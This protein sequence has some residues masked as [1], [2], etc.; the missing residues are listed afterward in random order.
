MVHLRL[1]TDHSFRVAAGKMEEVIACLPSVDCAITDR[2]GTWGHIRWHKLCKKSGKRA[3]F[4]VE[5]GVVADMESREKQHVNHMVFLARTS[6]GLQELY[7]L[8]S[9]STE[10]FYYIPRL[11]YDFVNSISDNII[12]LSGAHPEWDKMPRG[13]KNLYV[14]LNPLSAPDTPERAKQLGYQLVA[15]CDNIYPL[16]EDKALYQVAM[17]DFFREGRTAPG[18]ILSRWDWLSYWPAHA[19]ALDCAAEVAALCQ[20][21]LPQAKMVKPKVNKTLR[22]MCLDGNKSRGVNLKDKVYKARLDRELKLIADKGFEDYFFLVQDMIAWAKERM[23]VGPA[24]GSSCGSL[25]CFLIGI[26]DI[27]PIPFGLLFE[28][29]IDVNREDIPDIDID[30][31]DDRRELVFEYMRDKYGHDRVGRLGTINVFKPKSALGQCAKELQIPAWEI[32]DLKNA[33]VERSSGD[34]RA[35]FCI[36]D[37]FA[38]LD[39]GR[40]TLEKYPE[41]SL[42]GRIEGHASH[43]GMHAAGILITAEPVT[44]FCSINHHTSTAMIEKKDAEA[45]GLM[46]I[47]AL[48]LRTLSVL[49]DCLDQIGWSREDLR[50]WRL[51]DQ[52]A[53]DILNESRF[54]G[55]FQYEGYALQ[56][57]VKQFH[58]DRFEDVS[59][60]T[61]LARP[62][63]MNSG[64]ASDYVK[65]RAGKEAVS[66]GHPLLEAQTKLTFGTIVYQEQ[67]MTIARDVGQLSWKDVADLRLAMSRRLGDEYF[68]GHKANFRAGAVGLGM[69]AEEADTLWDQINT[70]GSWAFNRSHAVAYGMMSYWCCVLK[71]HFPLEFSAAC[72]RNAKDDEQ[73]VKILRELVIEGFKYKPYDPLTSGERWTV[74][75]GV[76]V[77][78]LV[79]IKGIGEKLAATIIK[80][81]EARIP[82]TPRERKLLEEGVTPWDKVF[83]CAE[84]W[85]HIF[86][87][88]SK[89][90]I[91]SQLTT[92]DKIEAE[93]DGTFCFIAKL[94]AKVPRDHNELQSVQKRNGKR[95]SGKTAYLNLTLEDDTSAILANINRHLYDTLAVPIIEGGKVGDWYIWKGENRNGFRR[96]YVKRWKKL[97]GVEEFTCDAQISEKRCFHL[98]DD[99]A[100]SSVSEE[101][102]ANQKAK[103]KMKTSASST[104]LHLSIFGPNLPQAEQ[105]L[106]QFHVHTTD[107]A[108]C[109]KLRKVI[110]QYGSREYKEVHDS[111][112]SVVRAIFADQI[113]E[114]A[115]VGDCAADVYFAPC[116]KFPSTKT[117]KTKT[118][119]NDKTASKS[120]NLKTSASKADSTMKPIVVDDTKK[121]LAAKK[122]T[123]IDIKKAQL[124][125]LTAWYNE[126]SGS[127]KQVKFKD[128][129]KAE[130]QCAELL[131]ALTE[132]AGGSSKKSAKTAKPKA[133]KGETDTTGRGRKSAFSGKLIKRAT[134]GGANPRREGSFGYKSFEVID[135]KK[136]T[137][138]E[139]YIAAGGRNNDLGYDVAHGFVTV[140]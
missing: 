116:V 103:T 47:D 112:E 122:F 69:P 14:E 29:F 19:A 23:F 133:E 21:E 87:N 137:R 58:I 78:G 77:G 22:Q 40:K 51:D 120:V 68:A 41:L 88:P 48:G 3:I 57:L 82:Y 109:G 110:K 128:R 6:A 113:A 134:E 31:Q 81:R 36:L 63:P 4:G 101:T 44:R 66:Y 70:F 25:V 9:L 74:Q 62:G 84:R 28:R 15:T 37:T 72:L 125:E 55:I 106:G 52:K 93:S 38:E 89:Y 102:D 53:F 45:I 96:I 94:M 73:S 115:T 136:G 86:R 124:P 140:E 135:A 32:N 108:D 139:D 20:A 16:P 117:S 114:G 8:T 71:A 85:G 99:A 79:G 107:C 26:T 90:G 91:E 43:T 39:I 2:D 83:E 17:G 50:R 100:S 12:I 127:K 42:A 60:I 27:D 61:A 11:D 59:V 92:L 119:K 67:V 34:S 64:A 24:R 130:A 138:Y 10:K 49:Q 95:M 54:A 126:N 80:K 121:D 118:M 98:G 75:D 129:A 76:L 97:T 1:R 131:V 65:R 56:S 46:K 7:E 35:T 132:L 13:K 111:T 30:F 104:S 33:I 18:H 105:Q 5:L 123:T